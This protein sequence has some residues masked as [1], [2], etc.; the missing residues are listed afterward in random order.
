MNFDFSHLKNTCLCTRNTHGFD[1]GEIHPNLGK[2][3][4]GQRWSQPHEQI[5][6]LEKKFELLKTQKQE[7]DVLIMELVNFMKATS[8]TDYNEYVRELI[9]RTKKLV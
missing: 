4:V 6:L 9:E 2:C 7:R 1:Y 3:G 5:E 8:M